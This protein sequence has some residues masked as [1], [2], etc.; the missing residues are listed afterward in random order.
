MDCGLGRSGKDALD[1][2]ARMN[3]KVLTS[4]WQKLKGTRSG[5]NSQC[6]DPGVPEHVDAKSVF[7]GTQHRDLCKAETIREV[8]QSMRGEEDFLEHLQARST[9][10]PQ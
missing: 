5:H 6:W 1:M 9:G 2:A 7:V 4:H 3:G 10:G 8:Q